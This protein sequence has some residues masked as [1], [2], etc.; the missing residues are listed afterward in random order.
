VDST[1]QS[2]CRRPDFIAETSLSSSSADE[3]EVKEDD[4]EDGK[5]VGRNNYSNYSGI[6]K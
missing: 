1:I 3:G 4:D 6:P 5:Q 2:K